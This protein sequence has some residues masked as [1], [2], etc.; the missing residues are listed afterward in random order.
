MPANLM[1]AEVF[2]LVDANG[3]YAV[4]NSRE[5]A[6]EKYEEDIQAVA[7]CEGF[8]LVKL[9]VSVPLP[10]AVTVDVN[11]PPGEGDPTVTV[12]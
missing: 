5:H 2:V 11:V 9:D 4:G 7:D 8:R 10:E 6:I 1:T 12:K 3:D